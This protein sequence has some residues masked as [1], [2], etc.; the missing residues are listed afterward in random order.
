VHYC[1]KYLN[2]RKM[3]I[4]LVGKKE[5]KIGCVH[6]GFEWEFQRCNTMYGKKEDT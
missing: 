2:E 3:R 6:A 5:K 4:L 1:E